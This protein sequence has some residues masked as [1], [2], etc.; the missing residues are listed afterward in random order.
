MLKIKAAGGGWGHC[1]SPGHGHPLAMVTILRRQDCNFDQ[2]VRDK[3]PSPKDQ[4]SV[5][6][7]KFWPQ[8][9]GLDPGD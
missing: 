3:L 4:L 1:S 8:G 2:K 6:S 7:H 5:L 9:S